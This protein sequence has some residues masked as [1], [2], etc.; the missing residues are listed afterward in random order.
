MCGNTI[1]PLK[2]LR[3]RFMWWSE[4]EGL[5]RVG[6]GGWICQN[7]RSARRDETAHLL[8]EPNCTVG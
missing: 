5:G 3:S 7:G 2:S 1:V 4:V 6:W 8:V